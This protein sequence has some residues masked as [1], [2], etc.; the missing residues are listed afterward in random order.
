MKILKKLTIANLRLNK[1]RSIGTTIGIILSVALICA[2]GI[3]FTSFQNTLVDTTAQGT[4]YYHIGLEGIDQKKYDEISKHQNVA[5][6]HTIYMLGW[7]NFDSSRKETVPYIKVFS[8]NRASF[9]DHKFKISNG[10]FPIDDDEI[11][12]SN[13]A[14]QDADLKIGDTLELDVGKRMTEDGYELDESNPYNGSEFPEHIENPAHK[15]Y[16]IVGTVERTYWNNSYFAITTK[17]KSNNIRA[18]IALKNPKIYKETMRELTLDST[19]SNYS[20]NTNYELLRWEI[21][22]FSDSTISMLYTICGIVIVII[23]TTSIF[24][25]RNSFAISTLEKMKMYGMLS[26]IGATK[27]QIK[28]SVVEEGMILGLI[29]VP[30]GV[31]SGIFADVVL[32]KVV[33]LIGPEFFG[34]TKGIVFKI[35]IVP[36]ILAVILGFVVIY[37]SSISSARKA[38]KVSPI[39]NLRNSNDIKIK[40]K[41]LKTPKIISGIF[42]TGGVLAYK[43][44]KR[45][46]KK[47]R[48]TVISLSV[49]IFVFISMNAFI[50]ETIGRSADY[51]T[52]YPYNVGIRIDR[53]NSISDE[54]LNAIRNLTDVDKSYVL[55]ENKSTL[56][57]KDLSHVII[58]KDEERNLKYGMG[59]YPV[60]F[61]DETFKSYAK[62]IGADYEYVKDKGIIYNRIRYYSEKKEKA[63]EGKR[64]TYKPG[65]IINAIKDYDEKNYVE[66]TVGAVTMTTPYGLE[67]NY[68]SGG[69]IVFDE[70]Y[71][72]NLELELNSILIESKNPNNVEAEIAKMNL[73]LAITNFDDEVKS[74]RSIVLIVSIFLYGFI[75]VITLIGVTNIFNTITA[76]ME[77]RSREFAILKSI[78]MTKREFNRMVNLETLFY[79]AKSLLYGIILGLCGAYAV[80]TA[81]QETLETE[82]ILPYSAIL[83]SIVFVL[84]IVFMIMRY[85]IAKINRQNTIET[86]RNE[87]I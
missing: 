24:C 46:K 63:I 56:N 8:I 62:S 48:T 71:A 19:T 25:I 10:R 22:A 33:N 18:F 21:F 61:D 57:I 66:L 75:T 67:N 73:S 23:M 79:S 37:L 81:F 11:L 70:K 35:S 50:N 29:G 17:E 28:K 72:E 42:K 31:L 76:N 38:S 32:I 2:T 53:D 34:G 85:S 65:D 59:L 83:I 64:Y 60:G 58:N 49:S 36:I 77:L 6:I 55:Y 13:K 9:D 86:I 15:T 16:K 52:D 12:I 3:L 74:Q 51:Y 68:F 69:Y 78:G 43:N 84:L 47:Y 26:S 4:G 39:E 30:L 14:L 41:K 45:S 5:N 80:H 87:N 1:K 82:F 40:S 27:K 20:S 44:L 7:A 54:E